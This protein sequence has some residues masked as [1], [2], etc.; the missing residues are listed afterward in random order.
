MDI[1]CSFLI[2][3]SSKCKLQAKRVNW[4]VIPLC[5]IDQA[6]WRTYFDDFSPYINNS[7]LFPFMLKIKRYLAVHKLE[8]LSISSLIVTLILFYV[9]WDY[10]YRS[11]AT[12]TEKQC[13]YSENKELSEEEKKGWTVFSFSECGI[14]Q[15][16][17]SKRL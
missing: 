10:F 14:S 12:I 15:L 2:P 3:T 1:C 11:Q 17:G 6:L 5:L 4:G 16:G 13:T 9:L 8:N 7:V